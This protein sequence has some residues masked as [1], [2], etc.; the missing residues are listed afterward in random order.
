MRTSHNLAFDARQAGLLA[1]IS[2]FGMRADAEDPIIVGY[3]TRQ[4][5]LIQRSNA[6]LAQADTEGRELSTEERTG[7]RDN[8]A[9]VERLEGEIELRQRVAAQDQRLRE[10]QPRRTPANG[11]EPLQL[12]QGAEDGRPQAAAT[13]VQTTHISTAATR[14]AQRGNG[15]FNTFGHFAQAVRAGILQPS[16]M[17]GRLRAAALSTW[18][19]ESTGADGGFAVPPDFK[20][21]IMSLVTAE[22]SLFS[23]CDAMPTASNKVEAV[24]DETSAYSTSGV[25]VYTRA[26]AAAMTQSKP[27]LK[28]IDCKLHELYAFV[29]VTDA[30]LDDAPMMSSFLTRKAGEAIQFKMNEYIVAG[31]GVGQML[32]I[33]NSGALVTAAAVGSQTADTLHGDNVVAMWA[34]MPGA[35]RNRAVWLINQDL[36][37]QLMKLGVVVGTA[38]GTAT[39]GMP[40]YMPPGGLSATPY[41]TL[42]GRP[43]ITTEACSAIGDVGDIILAFLGGYFAPYKAGGVKSDVSMHLY[44]DQGVT[45]F[46]WTMRVGG[47]PWLSA[48]IARKNGSNTLSH[49]VTLAA[50]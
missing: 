3:R 50:R 21:E 8:T 15:G 29:P 28:E 30:L 27:A 48:P 13:H 33:L 43:V 46:R 6:M 36:E 9:E 22:E 38:T 32:G 2:A 11:A 16:N 45:A 12:E 34:R 23:R 17:D 4:E 39:G 5:D 37:P 18:G 26:E 35:V 7:I 19:N 10:P 41:A 31:T 49:F 47:Q 40:V 42:L 24:T 1:F 14:A 20:S 25:R 44:F